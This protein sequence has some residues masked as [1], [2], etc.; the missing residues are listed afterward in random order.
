[1]KFSVITPCLNRVE[2]IGATIESVIAQDHSDF[3]HWIIDGGST[4]GTL[5]LLKRYRHLRLVS[6]PDRG[7][8]D[9]MNKGIRLATG[10]VVILLNSDDLLARG[11]LSLVADIFRNAVGTMIVSAGCQI[12]RCTPGGV[13]IEM[14]RYD[15]PRRNALSLRNVTIGTPNI[16]ARFFRRKVFEQIGE[17][18]LA[19]PIAADRDF[20]IRAALR[21]LP[22]APIAQVLY[23]YRW[24]AGSLTMNA[25]SESLLSGMQDGRRI[26]ARSIQNFSVN[27][28][29]LAC[30]NRWDR[31]CQATEVM[32]YAVQGRFHEALSSWL[33]GLGQ[34]PRFLVTF[35]RMGLLAIG[36]RLR[37]RWRLRK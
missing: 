5:E 29:Q 30:F 32:I 16:N 14:H 2:L 9:A 6:E 25:G 36:R 17:F 7:V 12:F 35:I 8:Y 26:I 37:T 4:D 33:K 15:E 10:E 24:H 20:L 28:E 22:D 19:Y 21:Q 11:A 34:D 1:M 31:E 27:R 18:D 23:R 3:E 13:E